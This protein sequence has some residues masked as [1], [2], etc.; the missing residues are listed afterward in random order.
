MD[1]LKIVLT[2]ALFAAAP[3]WAGDLTGPQKNAVR[4][5]KQYLSMTGFSR[6]GLIS[7]LSSDVGDG[8]GVSDATLAVDSLNIDWNQEAVRSAKQYLS[9]MGFSCKGLIKQLSSSA[10]DKYTVD[11]ATYGAKQAGGC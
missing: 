4:S 10:G 9:M 7:Q 11:Q 1:F 5:A 3:T 6:N 2:A 8:F